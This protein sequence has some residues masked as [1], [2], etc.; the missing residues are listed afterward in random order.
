MAAFEAPRTE[1]PG[2]EM[3]P[4]LLHFHSRKTDRTVYVPARGQMPDVIKYEGHIFIH[5]DGDQYIEARV[6]W[7]IIRELDANHPVKPRS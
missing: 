4:A 1:H 5:Q 3:R 6:V 7:P 2:R